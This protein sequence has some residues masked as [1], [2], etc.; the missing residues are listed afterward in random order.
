MLVIRKVKY[1]ALDLKNYIPKSS[2]DIENRAGNFLPSTGNLVIIIMFRSVRLMVAK[3][4]MKPFME[5]I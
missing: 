2:N 4:K 1:D 5:V 3:R